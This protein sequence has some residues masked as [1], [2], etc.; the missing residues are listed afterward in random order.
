MAA[1]GRVYFPR[2]K[3]EAART[4]LRLRSVTSRGSGALPA[5]FPGN[6]AVI[7]GTA[8]ARQAILVTDRACGVDHGEPVEEVGAGALVEEQVARP[9]VAVHVMQIC[10]ALRIP[11]A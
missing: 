2:A 5:I 10:R 11:A 4:R 9:E 7:R 6:D 1:R 8:L 3:R